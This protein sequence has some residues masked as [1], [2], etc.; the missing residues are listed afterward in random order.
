M[1]GEVSS[2]VYSATVT[3]LSG[4]AFP[5][6]IEITTTDDVTLMLGM[7]ADVEIILETHE[8]VIVVPVE[9]VVR[10]SGS[11]VVFIVRNSIATKQE[12][13]LGICTDDFCEIRGGIVPGMEVVVHNAALLDGG[14]EVISE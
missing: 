1:E 13:E 8:S 10:R 14:E 3:P 4:T 6:K 2:I 7:T 5:V 11:D 9:A 12:V